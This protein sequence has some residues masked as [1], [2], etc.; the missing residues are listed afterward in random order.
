M[1]K[2]IDKR[3]FLS[4]KAPENIID[5]SSYINNTSAATFS[6]TILSISSTSSY[7][8]LIFEANKI[9]IF[10]IRNGLA[11]IGD[12]IL[13]KAIKKENELNEYKK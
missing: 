7:S 9:S 5:G 4:R 12:F 10:S 3:T 1:V 13:S 8:Y 2:S 6:Q 11:K